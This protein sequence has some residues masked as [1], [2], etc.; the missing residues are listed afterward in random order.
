MV[1][2]STFFCRLIALLLLPLL[3]DTSTNS[4]SNFIAMNGIE[5]E[6]NKRKP[7]LIRSI[8]VCVCVVV[9]L[10]LLSAHDLEPMQYPNQ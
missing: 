2:S 1:R 3:K 4:H 10:C 6:R 8:C 5:N 9:S 7:K